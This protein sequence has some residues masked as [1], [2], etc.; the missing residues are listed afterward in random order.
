LTACP[1]GKQ[2]LTLN[3]SA[4]KSKSHFDIKVAPDAKEYKVTLS[5]ILNMF[6]DP[7]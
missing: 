5:H 4:K 2:E 3:A 6:S 1:T 7:T